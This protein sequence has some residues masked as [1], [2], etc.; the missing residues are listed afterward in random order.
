MDGESVRKSFGPKAAGAWYLHKHSMEDD[1]RHFVVYSSVA[2]VFGNIGQTNYAASNSYLDALVR[3]RRVRGL[4]G[5]S[6]QWPAI[7]EVG[8]AAV[9]DGSLRMSRE[10]MLD[11]TSVKNVLRQA[12]VSSC[13]VS[14]DDDEAAVKCPLRR[15]MLIEDHYP[16]R[17]RPFVSEVGIKKT[18][19]N[20][21]NVGSRQMAHMTSKAWT[22]DE[23]KSEVEAAVRRVI[24]TDD[25]SDVDHTSSMMGM[26]LD[27]LGSVELSRNLENR[28]GV[29]LSSTLVFSKPSIRDMSEYIHSLVSWSGDSSDDVEYLAVTSGETTTT[30]E[31][32]AVGMSC[33]FPGI[34]DGPD[35]FWDLISTGKKT[36]SS[37][38]YDRWD[39]DAL[40]VGIALS[41]EEKMRASHGLFVTDMECFDADFFG[42]S[43]AEAKAMDPQQRVLLECTYLAFKDAGYTM[44]DLRG[45]NCGVFVG[46][47]GGG[48]SSGMGR[49]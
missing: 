1:I 23:I 38:P 44:E 28:F 11:V 36:S 20:D 9:K 4:A 26:G 14:I 18:R 39:S 8:M 46:I 40:L 7:A 47:T 15:S 33:R 21:R 22:I 30:N 12:M 43:L 2:A 42:I 5:V 19:P 25:E 29:E 13:G 27:S 16:S 3:V 49:I 17:L 48:S 41:K 24:A 6:I 31:W 10:D 37:I 32:C 34:V 45:L 35:S